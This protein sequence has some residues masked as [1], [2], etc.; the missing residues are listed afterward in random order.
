M[1]STPARK[2]HIVLLPGSLIFPVLYQ[3]L[4]IHRIRSTVPLLFPTHRQTDRQDGGWLGYSGCS[5]HAKHVVSINTVRSVPA[6][7]VCVCTA[8]HGNEQRQQ[9]QTLLCVLC[10]SGNP[11]HSRPPSNGVVG[12]CACITRKYTTL[13]LH[14]VQSL[15]LS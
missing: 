11:R 1:W 10:I 3:H 9:Q 5:F 15:S 12:L 8:H 13:T 4:V 6:G 14:T 7:W 2:N